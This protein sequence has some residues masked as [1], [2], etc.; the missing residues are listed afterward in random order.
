MPPQIKGN[1]PPL[2]KCWN[3][4]L[5]LKVFEVRAN[6]VLAITYNLCKEISRV[7]WPRNLQQLDLAPLSD[8][9]DPA[10]TYIQ[11]FHLAAS[12]IVLCKTN[13]SLCITVSL[14]LLW[15]LNPQLLC[16][17]LM[18]CSCNPFCTTVDNRAKN[19]CQ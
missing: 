8:L 9:L 14:Q 2:C 1:F 11:M 4:N 7:R 6:L 19:F 3:C 5:P 17:V 12:T 18:C 10:K 16:N 15:C 13:S